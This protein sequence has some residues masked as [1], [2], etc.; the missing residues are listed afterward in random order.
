MARAT[1]ILFFILCISSF[2]EANEIQFDG[3]WKERAARFPSLKVGWMG[4]YEIKLSQSVSSPFGDTG[5]K[6]SGSRK[7]VSDYETMWIRGEDTKVIVGQ[8]TH[9]TDG[10]F[11]LSKQEYNFLN[12]KLPERAHPEAR[13][14]IDDMGQG[15]LRRDQLRPMCHHYAFVVVQFCYRPIESQLYEQISTGVYKPVSESVWAGQQAQVYDAAATSGS[16]QHYFDSQGYYL[17]LRSEGGFG[18]ITLE[19]EYE[20]ASDSKRIKRVDYVELDGDGNLNNRHVYTDFTFAFSAQVSDED[21]TINFPQ[22]FLVSAPEGDNSVGDNMSHIA[23]D[24]QL[25][26]VDSEN[27][28]RLDSRVAMAEQASRSSWIASYSIAL[29]VAVVASVFF[30][31]S[32]FGRRRN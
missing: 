26:V 9:T 32:R 14:K 13:I 19:V 18:T 3:I 5:S 21:L 25:K 29:L 2:G 12:A 24:G 8:V 4:T 7:I 17:G 31:A 28:E 27:L 11:I 15:W 22:G 30:F 20:D 23:L 6:E 1:W 10:E 16:M